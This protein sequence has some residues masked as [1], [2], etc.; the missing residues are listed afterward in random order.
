MTSSNNY[1][2]TREKIISEL[3]KEGYINVRN[4]INKIKLAT[5]VYFSC[6]IKIDNEGDHKFASIF[7]RLKNGRIMI[8]EHCESNKCRPR[9]DYYLWSGDLAT[10]RFCYNVYGTRCSD[11]KEDFKYNMPNFTNNLPKDFDNIYDLCG[12]Q[13][14]EEFLS[15]LPIILCFRNNVKM[16]D[17]KE[18]IEKLYI[19][20][21]EI[22]SEKFI[23]V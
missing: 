1:D 3:E 5:P 16:Y 22:F 21:R 9:G 20:Y 10:D 4:V 23:Y 8:Y 7:Y 13:D 17:C 12:G 14:Q 11:L 18:D 19:N 2:C 6:G 15:H